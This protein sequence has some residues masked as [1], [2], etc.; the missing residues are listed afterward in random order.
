MTILFHLP[1]IIKSQEISLL[2]SYQN[3]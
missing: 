3:W 1:L 2:K